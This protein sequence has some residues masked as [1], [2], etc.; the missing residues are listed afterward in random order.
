[1]QSRAPCSLTSRR[2]PGAPP[3]RRHLQGVLNMRRIQTSWQRVRLLWSR[4]QEGFSLPAKSSPRSIKA[5]LSAQARQAGILICSLTIARGEDVRMSG[6]MQTTPAGLPAVDFRFLS[7]SPLARARSIFTEAC[8][9]NMLC[10]RQRS[11][12]ALTPSLHLPDSPFYEFGHRGARMARKR[13]GN[14]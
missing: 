13:F 6:L 12:C 1:M 5:H 14:L 10:S 7:Q 8:S 11:K 2:C 3:T 4:F 9:N